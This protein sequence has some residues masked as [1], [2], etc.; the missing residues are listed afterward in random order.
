MPFD[1]QTQRKVKK[2]FKDPVIGDLTKAMLDKIYAHKS[3]K[4]LK[5]RDEI[6]EEE[7]RELPEMSNRLQA[8]LQVNNYKKHKKSGRER[9]RIRGDGS[10]SSSADERRIKFANYAKKAQNIQI[11]DDNNELERIYF[12]RSQAKNFTNKRHLY[13]K[14][15]DFK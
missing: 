7:V 14:L 2:F 10:T 4:S 12:L 6:E 8:L 15:S 5:H 3:Y 1:F 9:L 11:R 13:E